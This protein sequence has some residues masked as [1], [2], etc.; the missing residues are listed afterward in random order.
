MAWS[1]QIIRTLLTKSQV[2]QVNFSL[3]PAYWT[4]EYCVQYRETDLEFIE[5]LAAEEG[6]YYYFEHTADAHTLYFCN[7]SALSG[8]LGDLLYEAV[9]ARSPRASTMEMGISRTVTH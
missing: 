8:S 6:S 2:T 7:N 9:P 1:E 5:R 4:R 3:Q